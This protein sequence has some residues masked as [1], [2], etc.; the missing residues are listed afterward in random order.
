V[1]GYFGERLVE[2]AGRY[3]A[4]VDRIDRPWGEVFDPDEVDDDL[5]EAVIEGKKTAPSMHIVLQSGSN[6]ILKRMRRKYTK[7]DFINATNRLL[8]ANPRFTF[9]TDIIVGFPG[10]T[11]EEFQE[12]LDAFHK[13]RYSVAFMYTYSPRKGTPAMRWKDDVAEE[14][15]QERLHRLLE[16]QDEFSAKE[17]QD[18]L[19]ESIEV[20]VEKQNKEGRLSGRTR[21]WKKVVFEG[22]N[23]MIGTLQN[24]AL[25]GYNHQTL[26]ASLPSSS[27][28]AAR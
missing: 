1:L 4:Q 15:K 3:G 9:T 17:R 12:T 2:M 21:C 11:E 7:Q 16:L 25:T 23:E 10:E 8:K 18:M 14:V 20:L 6:L 27:L 13:I 26:I 22:P 24:V 28:Q 5:L 19:G